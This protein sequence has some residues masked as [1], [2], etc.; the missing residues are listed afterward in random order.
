[1]DLYGAK[2]FS[3]AGSLVSEEGLKVSLSPAQDPAPFLADTEEQAAAQSFQSKLL[4]YRLV[5][6]EQVRGSRIDCSAFVPEMRDEAR[7]WLAPIRDCRELTDSVFEEISRHSREA[8][9]ARFLDPKCVVAEAALFFCHKPGT[10]YFFVAELAGKVNALLAGRHE[11]PNLSA[12]RV[13]LLLRELGLYGDRVAQGYQIVLT[14]VARRRIHQL[15][16]DYRVPSLEDR[17]RRCDFCPEES[18]TSERTQ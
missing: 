13:G 1:L 17:V 8:A 5:N 16:S 18:A 10:E 12:K 4:R 14:D 6:Y 7:A 2:A 9:G 15:A 3:C 11:E